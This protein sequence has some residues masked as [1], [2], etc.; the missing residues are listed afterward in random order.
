[1]VEEWAH[2]Q[3]ERQH[4]TDINSMPWDRTHG[5]AM[6]MGFN[7]FECIDI[8]LKN[9]PEGGIVKDFL[10]KLREFNPTFLKKIYCETTPTGGL[11]LIYKCPAVGA[12]RVL[13]RNKK[14]DPII[15]TKGM[16]GYAI[17]AP[18]PGYQPYKIV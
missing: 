13:A 8:D 11:H 9:D 15:E 6:I 7:D 2:W 3:T 4:I 10:S 16:G 14:G 18:T 5:I 12:S 17:V 1:M